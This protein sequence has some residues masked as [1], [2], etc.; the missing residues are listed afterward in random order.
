MEGIE[1]IKKEVE[2][3]LNDFCFI[4]LVEKRNWLKYIYKYNG[5]KFNVF[6][7]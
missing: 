4:K 7:L 2:I 3:R 6:M 1:E 5:V